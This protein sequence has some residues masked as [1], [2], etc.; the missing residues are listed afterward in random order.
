V[1]HLPATHSCVA[2][3]PTTHYSAAHV[4]NATAAMYLSILNCEH[5][6][7]TVFHTFESPFVVASS[8]LGLGLS[9]V[10]FSII[11]YTWKLC[12]NVLQPHLRRTRIT[13]FE[14]MQYLKAFIETKYVHFFTEVGGKFRATCVDTF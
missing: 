10:A 6:D 2:G 14:C 7:Q 12:A 13:Q 8:L 1:T 9:L 5:S 11:L 3:M 4:L